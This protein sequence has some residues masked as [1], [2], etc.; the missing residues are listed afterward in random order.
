MN[1]IRSYRHANLLSIK[2]LKIYW[3]EKVNNE[4]KSISWM[5]NLR[6]KRAISKRYCYFNVTL[7]SCSGLQFL[8]WLIYITIQ[9]TSFRKWFRKNIEI[10]QFKRL[11]NF[12]IKI[13]FFGLVRRFWYIQIFSFFQ[14]FSQHCSL[15][16]GFIILA[17]SLTPVAFWI[18]WIR[19]IISFIPVFLFL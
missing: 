2:C 19:R 3:S 16:L 17:I 13:I 12:N 4:K 8:N 11:F 10:L 18:T 7:Q 5:P 14:Y 15:F 6:T 1:A 9:K